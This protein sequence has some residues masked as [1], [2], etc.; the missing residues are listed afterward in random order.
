MDIKRLLSAAICV[1]GFVAYAGAQQTYN[2]YEGTAPGSENADY[3]ELTIV[4]P[5]G[6]PLVY[7][8]TV[9]TITVFKPM[10]EID[11]GAAVVIA[12]G[13]GNM[14]LTW[15]CEGVNVARWLQQHGI[16]GIL[17]KYRTN[18]MGRTPE[19]INKRVDEV[20]GGRYFA[21]QGEDAA[22]GT[23]GFTRTTPRPQ[24][25][26]RIEPT[27][28]GNDGRK[29]IQFVREHSSEWGINPDKIG[30]MGFSAGGMLVMDVYSNH[31]DSSAPNLIAP[32]Y[33]ARDVELPSGAENIPVFLCSPEFDGSPDGPFNFFKRL[34]QEHY[35]AEL[36]FI[37]DAAHGQ[38]LLYNGREWNEWIEM[39]YQFAKAVKFVE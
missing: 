24:P 36:H 30:I 18:F 35:P 32:I 25:S 7:N 39:F 20:L 19:E 23:G 5:Y 28:Q 33:G 15:E 1:L 3:D 2:L 13:G 6:E 8:V 26:L 27:L 31:D 10:Q 14:Y 21:E 4:A 38:G 17:L 22:R 34:Q 12:P 37:H 29:A 16:T 9:P 11:T